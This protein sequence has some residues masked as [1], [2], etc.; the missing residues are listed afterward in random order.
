[1]QRISMTDYVRSYSLLEI[2]H[3]LVEMGKVLGQEHTSILD[4]AFTTIQNI[5]APSSKRTFARFRGEINRFQDFRRLLNSFTSFTP[6]NRSSLVKALREYMQQEHDQTLSVEDI[7]EHIDQ[8][9]QNSAAKKLLRDYVLREIKTLKPLFNFRESNVSV[10]V[11]A[12]D[13]KGLVSARRGTVELDLLHL[14]RFFTWSL[15][16]E[17]NQKNNHILHVVLTTICEPPLKVV[18]HLKFSGN[19]VRFRKS[20]VG[21]PTALKGLTFESKYSGTTI[22][23]PPKVAEVISQQYIPGLILEENSLKP[24]MWGSLIRDSIYPCDLVVTF[25]QSG[26][27]SLREK[28]FRLYIGMDGY[29]IM[30]RFGWSIERQTADWWI[31]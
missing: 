11:K 17:K 7:T 13:P 24:W 26:S 6:Y 19:N 18:W 20:Y 12:D 16:E 1:M 23:L 5:Y 4:Q 9:S 21:K 14:L 22:P 29:R 28:T 10:N 2:T 31:V 3:P 27:S 25:D 15:K 30:A 8:F